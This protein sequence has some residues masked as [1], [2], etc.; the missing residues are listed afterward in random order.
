MFDRL[1]GEDVPARF[2]SVLSTPDAVSRLQ[3]L[4]ARTWSVR[5]RPT[6]P[7]TIGTVSSSNVRLF[8]VDPFLG[9]SFT[10]IFVGA[11][12]EEHGR[13]VLEGRFTMHWFAEAVLSCGVAVLVLISVTVTGFLIGASRTPGTFLLYPA[14]GLILVVTLSWVALLGLVRLRRWLVRDHVALISETIRDALA[15]TTTAESS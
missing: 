9:N 2:E 11:F 1:F 13:T 6:A 7:A 8:R 5:K 12:R 3:A 14:L 10:P 15:E 4:T